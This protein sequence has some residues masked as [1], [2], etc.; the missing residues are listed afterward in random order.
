MCEAKII[1]GFCLDKDDDY[2]KVLTAGQIADLYEES[3]E[4]GDMPEPVAGEPA[5]PEDFP[6][7]LAVM[8]IVDVYDGVEEDIVAESADF[9]NACEVGKDGESVLIGVCL[10]SGSASYKGVLGIPKI[11]PAHRQ[12]LDQFVIQY[13]QFA[14][15]K[16]RRWFYYTNEN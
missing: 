1:Y 9:E 6:A 15:F 14:G 13:P 8:K 2:K 11:T 7:Y 12:T 5:E 3:R 4:N 10:N 16:R